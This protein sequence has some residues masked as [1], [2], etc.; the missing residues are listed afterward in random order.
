MKGCLKYSRTGMSGSWGAEGKSVSLK[1]LHEN[2]TFFMSFHGIVKNLIL[3]CIKHFL[4]KWTSALTPRNGCALDC[5]AAWQHEK[6]IPFGW[7]YTTGYITGLYKMCSDSLWPFD[8]R[9]TLKLAQIKTNET[10][11]MW[12]SGQQQ[13][14]HYTDLFP[15]HCTTY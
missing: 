12:L 11:I 5:G 6:L 9:T 1:S 7:I 14:F 4:L 3:V 2:Q 15:L 8:H 13:L 10:Y